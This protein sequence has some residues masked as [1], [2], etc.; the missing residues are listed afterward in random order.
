L[1]HGFSGG[2][3][4]K[5]EILQ[6]AILKPQMA[7]MDETD[8]GLDVDALQ[9]VCEGVKTV[10]ED[11]EKPMGILMVTHYQRILK[12]LEPDHV[13]VMKD[14]KIVKSGG[15]EFAHELEATGYE[16]L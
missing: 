6:M 14:G 16:S 8:S 1:N 7:I 4:K 2:E 12:Y 9:T 3:K 11:A 13:H 5:A 10:R 15:K